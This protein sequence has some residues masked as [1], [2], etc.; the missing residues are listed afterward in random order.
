MD[1]TLC[2]CEY[3]ENGNMDGPEVFNNIRIIIYRRHVKRADSLGVSCL[4]LCSQRG[5]NG[6][7]FKVE[8][9][10]LTQWVAWSLYNKYV[11]WG[12]FP[13]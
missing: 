3:K 10:L 7:F 8:A 13:R 2:L 11:K 6:R 4:A 9:W 5:L 1:N 12:Q